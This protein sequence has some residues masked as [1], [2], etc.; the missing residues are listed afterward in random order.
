MS[1]KSIILVCHTGDD[2]ESAER[3]LAVAS[4]MEKAEQLI[5]KIAKTGNL[6]GGKWCLRE[7]EID[8]DFNAPWDGT[9][10]KKLETE[11]KVI[12]NQGKDLKK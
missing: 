7:A 5:G 12:V 11:V 6:Y 1:L 4:S 3:V 8:R 9:V 10:G 2:Y